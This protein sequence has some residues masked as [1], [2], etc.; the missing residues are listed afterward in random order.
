MSRIDLADLPAP[1]AISHAGISTAA[2]AFDAAR[3]HAQQAKKDLTELE[4]TRESAEWKDAE[5]VDQAQAAGKPAPKLTAVIAHDKLTDK[6][7]LD[8][9]VATLAEAR[10]RSALRAALDTCGDAYLAEVEK[11]ASGLD[12]SWDNAVKNLVKLHAEHRRA[13]DTARKLGSDRLPVEKGSLRLP[14][15]GG[16]TVAH[17]ASEVAYVYASDLIGALGELGQTQAEPK[18]GG[19]PAQQATN[20][21]AIARGAHRSPADAAELVQASRGLDRSIH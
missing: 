13:T 1:A 5:A 3:L 4:Q 21:A 11:Q 10:T 16:I 14:Q 2:E 6:A 19:I 15:L 17:G 20:I 18:R 8:L 12:A 7:K 9:K